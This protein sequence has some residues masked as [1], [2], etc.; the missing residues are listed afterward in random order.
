MSQNQT[1]AY[2]DEIEKPETEKAWLE[3]RKVQ[4]KPLA[5]NFFRNLDDNDKKL[6]ARQ[7][8]HKHRK[9]FIK[10]EWALPPQSIH[11]APETPNVYNDGSLKNSLCQWWSVGGI[12]VFWPQRNLESNPLNINEKEF[13][14]AQDNKGVMLSAALLGHRASSTRAELGAGIAAMLADSPTHQGTD[15]MA[16]LLKA[17][18]ILKGARPKKPWAILTDGDLWEY[19]EK[20]VKAKGAHAID[21]SKVKGHATEKMV[22]EGKVLKKDK[23][24]NDASDEA[25]DRGVEQHGNELLEISNYFA[26]AHAEYG[27]FMAHMHDFILNRMTET[28]KN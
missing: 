19:F 7:L 25:A 16:Y 15:S 20:I 27:K 6:N 17:T 21:I 12:G 14:V 10:I 28:D 9:D 3:I 4:P 22:A 5:K 18:Q 26:Q 23:E 8:M 11:N 13:V 1:G 24:G 2:W